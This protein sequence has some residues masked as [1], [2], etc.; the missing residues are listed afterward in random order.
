[1]V[2]FHPSPPVRFTR[3]EAWRRRIDELDTQYSESM[4]Q[5]E[6]SLSQQARLVRTLQIALKD[7]GFASQPVSR[8]GFVDFSPA[9]DPHGVD[10]LRGAELIERLVEVTAIP[11][12]RIVITGDTFNA[13]S[14]ALEEISKTEGESVVTRTPVGRSLNATA[15]LGELKR[16]ARDHVH[17]V[18][19][20]SRGDARPHFVS[21]TP[22]AV[23]EL[24]GDHEDR[25][26]DVIK[27]VERLTN[28]T[29]EYV[30]G[31]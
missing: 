26:R 14:R 20:F 23:I 19:E 2:Q 17:T 11:K 21:Q 29:A 31:R 27:S 18:E 1:M 9:N 5:E 3:Y 12:A 4:S 13:W 28:I 6:W 25:L 22:H 30:S 15:A 16:A 7:I 8:H 10:E 24:C